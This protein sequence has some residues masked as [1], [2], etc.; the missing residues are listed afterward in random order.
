MY[1]TKYRQTAD[2]SQSQS[3]N[4][5][6][7]IAGGVGG[8]GGAGGNRGGRGGTGQGT[9]LRP[10]DVQRFSR[11]EGGTGGAGGDS[12]LSGN[13][14]GGDGGLGERAALMGA[15]HFSVNVRPVLAG[16]NLTLAKFCE[17]YTVGKTTFDLLHQA[18]FGTAA[19][20]LEVSD[21][22]LADC[23]LGKGHIGELKR[24]LR[25]WSSVGGQK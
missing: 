1:S 13:G 25:E 14:V 8:A 16:Q 15:L 22:D 11:I 21:D 10:E 18:G 23:G 6:P 4:P 7:I 17:K 12:G 9:R 3:P 20:L 2:Q 24:A 5:K 19:G